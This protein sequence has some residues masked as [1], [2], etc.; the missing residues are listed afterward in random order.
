VD[1]DH[2]ILCMIYAIMN[3]NIVRNCYLGKGWREVAEG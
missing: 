3:R 2:V 1:H